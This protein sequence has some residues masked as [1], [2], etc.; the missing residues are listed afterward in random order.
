MCG[1][2]G[3]WAPGALDSAEAM[4]RRVR[5]MAAM[6]AHR[7][8]DDLEGWSDGRLGLGYTRLAII[9][10]SNHAQQPMIDPETGNVLVFNGEIYN[11]QDLRDELIALGAKF[12]S[13]GDTETLLL[14]Y[15][16]WGDGIIDRLRGMFCFALWDKGQDR[17][18]I[19]RDRAGQKPLFYG[20]HQGKLLFGSEIKTL[21]AWPDLPREPNP[22]ALSHYFSYQAV[23]APLTAYKGI[24][25]LPP[26]HKLVIDSKGNSQLERYWSLPA[27][28]EQ[29]SIDRRTAVEELRERLKEAVRSQLVADVP[30]GAFLSGGLDSSS[31]V[32]QMQQLAGG[33]VETFTLGFEEAEQDE[34]DSARQVAKVLG[35][36]HH[37]AVLKPGD[38]T[39]IDQLAWYYD[40]PFAD[41]SAIPTFLLSRFTAKRL[42]VVLSGDAGD[43]LFMGYPRYLACRMTGFADRLPR[44]MIGAAASIEKLMGLQA[45]SN[46][47]VRRAGRFLADLGSDP[48]SRYVA[49]VG[50]MTEQEK[51]Q[52]FGPALKEGL[53]PPAPQLLAP[54]FKEGRP[55]EVAAARADFHHYL[56]DVI[57]TKVDIASMANGLE[58]RA[59][60]LDHE[61]VEWISALPTHLKFKGRTAKVLLK[62]AAR[63]LLP[64]SIID[65]RKQGFNVPLAQ[66]FKGPLEELAR[67]ALLSQRSRERGLIDPTYAQ[68]L[69]EDHL[70]GRRRNENRI[71]ALVMQELWMRTWID[72]T[73][74]KTPP[75]SV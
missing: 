2:V 12:Q 53:S 65:R 36:T 6:I 73:P 75:E 55:A 33:R 3:F 60:F 32:A 44:G 63:G 40:Q 45:H 58:A 4:T 46:L 9:D 28:N 7:G 59:P 5:E 67:D 52:A 35:T 38:V 64:D 69:L 57:L 11:Y 68:Q 49:W 13:H 22:Q 24:S 1:I 70:S 41:P 8:P 31:I 21:F 18:L 54:W 17:L 29:Q 61:L 42:K 27:P 25:A 66:W 37:E 50:F 71:W 30:V 39:W 10:L 62:E 16:Y 72:A 56:P 51:A 15:R 19:A 43:E 34:R 20:W 47:T 14:G 26:A 23:P 48:L 74:R